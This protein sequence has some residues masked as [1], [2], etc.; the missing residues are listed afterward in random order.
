VLYLN[1]PLTHLPLSERRKKLLEVQP[2][3]SSIIS[4][5]CSK[6]CE[7]VE[8]IDG[9]LQEAIKGGT[10]GLMI[11][12]MGTGY[13]CSRR[14][15]DWVKLKKDYLNKLG[16]TLDVVPI[17]GNYGAGK[18][19][20]LFGAYLLAIYNPDMEVYETLCKI[21]TGFSDVVL[22]EM[23]KYFADKAVPNCPREYRVA[24]QDEADVWFTPSIV[25]EV[26]GADFQVQ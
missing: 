19:T 24:S 5:I 13:F 15:W 12:D 17:G 3:F 18:R 8:E 22:E 9:F 1:G 7:S 23:H 11:K 21:G 16:D 4:L 26:K 25:W 2:S 20:G 6:E 14:S 10:E